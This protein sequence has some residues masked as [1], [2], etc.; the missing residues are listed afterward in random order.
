MTV[1]LFSC[2]AASRLLAVHVMAMLSGLYNG[3]VT[4]ITVGAEL[5]TSNGINRP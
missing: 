5:P 1:F 2:A 3:D 4:G